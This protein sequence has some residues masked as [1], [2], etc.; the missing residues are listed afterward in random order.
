MVY[1][2]SNGSVH[3]CGW[4]NAGHT[5]NFWAQVHINEMN[6]RF[7]V[8]SVQNHVMWCDVVGPV[9]VYASMK[10]AWVVSFMTFVFYRSAFTILW[11]R[12]WA[13]T[14]WNCMP[15]FEWCGM[16]ECTNEPTVCWCVCVCVNTFCLIARMKTWTTFQCTLCTWKFAW[17]ANSYK[18]LTCIS[19]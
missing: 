1:C 12:L 4:A 18:S 5:N 3:H 14:Y 11:C 17:N 16:N 19:E 8:Q 10:I 9:Y 13:N 2:W 15:V 7:Y 6:C